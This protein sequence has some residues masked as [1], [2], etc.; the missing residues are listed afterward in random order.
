[1]SAFIADLVRAVAPARR[2][3]LVGSDLARRAA[4]A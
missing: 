2:K 4:A 1:M 3:V